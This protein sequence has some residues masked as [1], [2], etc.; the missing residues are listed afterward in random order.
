MPVSD[1][2]ELDATLHRE[3]DGSFVLLFCR[4]PG[5]CARTREE[6]DRMSRA[7]VRCGDCY[8]ASPEQTLEEVREILRRGDA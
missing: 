7:R 8:P 3:R 1:A 2:E 5:R 4:G 6:K